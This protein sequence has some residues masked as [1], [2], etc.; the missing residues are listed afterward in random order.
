MQKLIVFLLGLYINTINLISSKIG[1]KHAFLLFCYPFPLKLKP[2]QAI[3]LHE[4][5]SNDHLFEGKKI[6]TYKWGE[7]GEVI[8]C[9]HGWQSNSYRWKKYIES[10]DKEK[11][12]I[13]SIDA[14]AHGESDGRI[15]NVPM[16]ARLI[17]ELI[18]EYRVNYI[19]AHSLGAF[20]TMCLF[21]EKPSLSLDKVAMLGT[22]GEATDFIDEYARILKVHPRVKENISDYF[23][24]YAGLKPSYYSTI[25]FAENQTSKA[26]LIHDTDDKEAPYHYVEKVHRLWSNSRLY[27][28][29]GLGHK[30]RGIEVVDEVVGFFEK[31]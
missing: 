23:V 15:F 13:I 12:T 29:S 2:E 3:F 19:L 28:T 16:Y 20:A 27:T 4:A 6:A 21:Y 1:G 25:R 24:S 22:P 26:L 18:S 10:L 5:R 8:L 9:L 14:P 17:E 11:Y 30:L 7:G 31:D